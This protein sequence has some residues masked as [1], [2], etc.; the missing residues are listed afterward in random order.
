M[1]GIMLALQVVVGLQEPLHFR[2]CLVGTFL[3]LLAFDAEARDFLGVETLPHH[4]ETDLCHNERMTLELDRD[5]AVDVTLQP[6]ATSKLRMGFFTACTST[7]KNAP[8]PSWNCRAN[9]GK[10][11]QTSES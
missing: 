6:P 7:E 3:S 8:P 10:A 2:S 5:K 4:E 1:Q 9:V 11:L